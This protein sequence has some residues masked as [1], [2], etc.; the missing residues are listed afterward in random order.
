MSILIT[1]FAAQ[2]ILHYGNKG[3]I[4][5]HGTIAI[6]CNVSNLGRAY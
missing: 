1:K 5:Q 6:D 4:Q 2:I 3:K